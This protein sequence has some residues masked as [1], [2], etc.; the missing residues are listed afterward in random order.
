MT[1]PR[2]QV[3]FAVKYKD[4]SRT[5]FV[6]EFSK[7]Y[8]SVMTPSDLMKRVRSLWDMRHVHAV[9]LAAIH[10]KEKEAQ[11]VVMVPARIITKHVAPSSNS[12]P[13]VGELLVR[14]NNL[15]AELVQLQKEQIAL[16]NELKEVKK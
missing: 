2:D 16:F 4:H 11:H 9:T 1:T 6:N 5:E 15:L 13:D 14:T 3:E 8:I 7:E 10:E 12:L